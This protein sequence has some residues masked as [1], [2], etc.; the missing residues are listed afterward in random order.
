MTDKEI[1]A[2]AEWHRRFQAAKEVRRMRQVKD[3]RQQAEADELLKQLPKAPPVPTAL[4]QLDMRLN[5]VHGLP[6][7][8]DREVRMMVASMP[9]V[10]KTRIR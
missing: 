10:P 9:S 3:R 7:D 6:P 2:E 4:Q 1:A 5:R 8:T